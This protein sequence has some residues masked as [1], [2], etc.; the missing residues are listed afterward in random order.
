[1]SILYFVH[2]FIYFHFLAIV[3][4][5]AVNL[6]EF[7]N[8]FKSNTLTEGFKKLFEN[9]S[10]EEKNSETK[11]IRYLEN[12]IRRCCPFY[13]FAPCQLKLLALHSWPSPVNKCTL[14]TGFAYEVVFWY[15]FPNSAIWGSS[16]LS[17]DVSAV[18]L[19]L[20][21]NVSS[22]TY[23]SCYSSPFCPTLP[24][25]R[26]TGYRQRCHPAL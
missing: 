24:N 8:A 6:C 12:I 23:P 4:N 15:V 21:V 11:T 22:V 9:R 14:F 17:V 20:M 16:V 10:L 18:I 7:S 3:N 13:I 2:P 5:A 1:M 26:V 25:P 19:W